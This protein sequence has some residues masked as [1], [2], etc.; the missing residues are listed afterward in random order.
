ML[1]RRK[2][3]VGAGKEQEQKKA[4]KARARLSF[5]EGLRAGVRSA[6]GVKRRTLSRRGS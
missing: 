3:W 6:R 5:M 2:A 1:V 4:A